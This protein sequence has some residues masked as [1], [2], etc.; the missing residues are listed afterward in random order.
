MKH[1][2]PIL[3]AA[4]A[5][6]A[7]TASAAT[8]YTQEEF[9]ANQNY[10]DNFDQIVKSDIVEG[11]NGTYDF[12]SYEVI[13]EGNSNLRIHVNEDIKLYVYDFVD[14]VQSA[15]N[16]ASALNGV[17]AGQN[18]LAVQQIGYRKI[19]AGSDGT[20]VKTSDEKDVNIHSLGDPTD[21]ET[22]NRKE[23]M[24]EWY[25][26]EYDI[27]RNSYYLGEF[28]ADTDYELFVS[29]ATDGSD[30]KWSYTDNAGGYL[31]QT[32]KLMSANIKQDFLSIYD[33]DIYDLAQV[34]T[35]LAQVNNISFGLRSAPADPVVSGSPLPGGLQIA[36]IAGLFGLG[37]W[38]VRRRKATVA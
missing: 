18:K 24:T 15:D 7:M 2:L 35:P 12:G 33:Q 5:F 20:F 17:N 9:F 16:S 21:T 13:F 4:L 37:F 19:V 28:K 31:I 10:K 29:Y 11:H 8:T 6:T 1:L 36:L 26:K 32:D 27:V 23:K 14:N 25:T 3:T 22:I 30:G 34:Y 38:Y